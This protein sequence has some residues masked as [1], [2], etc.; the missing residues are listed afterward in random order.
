MPIKKGDVIGKLKFI[1]K[2][3]KNRYIDVVSNENVDK[4]NIFYL[5]LN[6]L[7]DLVSGN[8]RIF[9]AKN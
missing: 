8:M 4:A 7:K 6:N 9:R 1:V 3:E 5:Y 2:G